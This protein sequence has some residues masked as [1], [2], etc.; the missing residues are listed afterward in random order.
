M[1]TIASLFAG[2][3]LFS[4]HFVQSED[5]RI[6]AQTLDDVEIYTVQKG[7]T[8]FDIALQSGVPEMELE[9]MNYKESD[10]IK[11]G[12]KIIVPKSE[13]T[14]KEEDLLARLVHAEAK[15]EPFDGKVAV[16]LVVL[17]RVSDERFPDTIKDVIYEKKQFQPVDNGSINKSADKEA[18]KAVKEAIALDGKTDDETVFFF[19]PHI[20]SKTWLQTRTVTKEIGNHR[21]AK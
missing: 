9:K 4:F 8:L 5:K 20:V 19:N 7:E 11:A 10:Q 21:F 2:V 3:L 15:G 13:I 6:Y 18:K 16:A 14:E 17:N 1:K 12:E